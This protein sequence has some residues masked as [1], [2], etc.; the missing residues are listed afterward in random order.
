[1]NAAGSD[2]GHA[3]RPP[4]VVG[5]RLIIAAVILGAVLAVLSV[6]AT[7]M[8]PWSE[9]IRARPPTPGRQWHWF[10]PGHAVLYTE[11]D[12][13]G[14]A[15]SGYSM[16]RVPT[17]QEGA[18]ARQFAS[19]ERSDI[20]RRAPW[21]VA[22]FGGSNEVVL[23]VA[24]GWP[25]HAAWGQDRWLQQP[26]TPRTHLSQ[27]KFELGGQQFRLPLRPLWPGLAAN[28]AFYA[29]IALAGLVPLSCAR[30]ARRRR[31]RRC[32]ACNY[33]LSA[34]SGPCPECGTL[35]HRIAKRI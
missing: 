1:M 13:W 14:L 19:L 10:E 4:R 31:R 24:A 26:G 15:I 11:R 2:Q 29:P 23:A 20:D 3:K 12:V 21:A 16:V 18:Y 35:D 33:D 32:V 25:W 5:V 27:A 34:S 7:A 17:G 28:T 22:P 6:P 9:G 8:S 30:R